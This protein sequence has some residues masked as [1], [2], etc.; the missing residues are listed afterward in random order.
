M[1]AKEA[2]PDLP[3][4]LV[5]WYEYVKWLSTGLAP[6]KASSFQDR[7]AATPRPGLSRLR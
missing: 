3:V 6:V 4:V 5:K 2:V 7:P 1:T